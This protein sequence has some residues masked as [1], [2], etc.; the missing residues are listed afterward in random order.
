MNLVEKGKLCEE[1]S[2]M[3][4]KRTGTSYEN[5]PLPPLLSTR[6]LIS[7]SYQIAEGMEFLSQ[8]KVIHAD[9]AA[10]NILLTEARL[11]KICD[12]GLARQLV[13]YNYVKSEQCP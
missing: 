3:T 10:R 7:W 1:T 11:V 2:M 9:L 13:D 5:V 8:K 4:S 12:F 6:D